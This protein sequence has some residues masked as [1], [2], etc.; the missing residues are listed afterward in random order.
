M[1]DAA[2]KVPVGVEAP[3]QLLE[4]ID[5]IMDEESGFAIGEHSGGRCLA[6]H[7]GRSVEAGGFLHYEAVGVVQGREE[8]EAGGGVVCL[9]FLPVGYPA[10]EGDFIG[11]AQFIDQLLHFS[12]RVSGAH[13]EHPEGEV[14]DAA[15]RLD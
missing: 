6:Q 7:H 15:Q 5:T 11:N 3:Q 14:L 9:K 13:E 10:H 2:H 12:F 4:I 1:A 8:E